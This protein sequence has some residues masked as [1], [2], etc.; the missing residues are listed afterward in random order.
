MLQ[1]IGDC[2][3]NG[4]DPATIEFCEARLCAWVVE[5]AAAWTSLTK[6]LVG[7]IILWSCRKHLDALIAIG[8]AAF[9]QGFF[10]F[11]LHA[12]G[13]FWGEALDVSG[14]FIISGLFLAFAARR[15]YG[16]SNRKVVIFFCGL[17]GLSVGILLAIRPSGIYVFS[18]QIFLWVLLEIQ[19]FRTQGTSTDYRYLKYLVIT[20]AI[21][22]AVWIPDITGLVCDPD[23]HI[24]NLHSLWHLLT[25]LAIYW[26]YRYQAQFRSPSSK[27]V[28]TSG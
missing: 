28:G 12:T 8:V 24:F 22:F 11:A 21:A 5:P 26:F 23:N 14:M 7:I 25:S 6:T 16:W 18:A 9:L 13:T 3:W 27:P 15:M 20:F 10:G 2:P 19:L 17:V 1:A 4:F